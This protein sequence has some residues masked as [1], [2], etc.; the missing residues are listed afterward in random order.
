MPAAKG[1][2][3]TRKRSGGK[4]SAPSASPGAHDVLENTGADT[5][6]LVESQEHQ[7]AH[8]KT[9]DLPP[10]LAQQITRDGP[11]QRSKKSTP[12]EL[13][14]QIPG[15]GTA[16]EPSNGPPAANPELN[17]MQ[18][19]RRPAAAE[20]KRLLEEIT[21]REVGSDVLKSRPAS[22]GV[23]RGAQKAILPGDATLHTALQAG[24]KVRKEIPV[25]N[26]GT[27][28]RPEHEQ[29]AGQASELDE[30]ESEIDFEL[31]PAQSTAL[32]GLQEGMGS[33]E[34]PDSA[35]HEIIFSFE[36]GVRE[37]D[38]DDRNREFSESDDPAS[39]EELVAVGKRKG[40]KARAP[41]SE[42]PGVRPANVLLSVPDYS[43][44]KR[45]QTTVTFVK[46]QNPDF[47]TAHAAITKALGGDEKDEIKVEY[48][49]YRSDPVKRKF[50]GLDDW[51]EWLNN[52]EKFEKKKKFLETILRN[53]ISTAKL[54]NKS[55][56]TLEDRPVNKSA[57]GGADSLGLSGTSKQLHAYKLIRESLEADPCG[58]PSCRDKFCKVDLNGNHGLSLNELQAWGD[59]FAAGID[60]ATA[61]TPPHN[62]R[63]KR[64]HRDL[65]ELGAL[66]NR[67]GVPTR[68]RKHKDKDVLTGLPPAVS[69][70][71]ERFDRVL[72]AAPASAAPRQP[73]RVV[74]KLRGP[75]IS[76]FLAELQ[77]S[78]GNLRNY[79]RY[80]EEF[81]AHELCF[82]GE[83]VGWSCEDFQARIK[84]Q[85]GSAQMVQ[86][87]VADKMAELEGMGVARVQE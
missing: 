79:V 10:D 46:A 61:E 29:E 20:A 16:T 74:S 17:I 54:T 4:R 57:K 63:F 82:I 77:E 13:P 60:G 43:K 55:L 33:D 41:A 25:A 18:R 80:A 87:A 78:E 44:P 34:E 83:L 71:F 85:I 40:K 38:E 11:K 23:K 14:S 52:V 68:D 86:Q 73:T 81:A 8:P 1:K 5:G 69:Q 65:L 62:E 24:S 75:K 35:V 70:F 15:D 37:V 26:V 3:T 36:M 84:M 6:L 27:S 58:K 47:V 28:T 42:I 19:P 21:A 39:E 53:P 48:K 9:P 66:D 67:P 30:L 56:Q 64:F 2:L 50:D 76:D 7:P 22:K 12:A 49:M 72:G 31:A 45:P 59:A 51:N 32:E